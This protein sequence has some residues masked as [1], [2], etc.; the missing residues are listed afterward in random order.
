MATNIL[1]FRR[2]D[3]NTVPPKR[4][5]K[6]RVEALPEWLQDLDIEWIFEEAEDRQNG[7][8]KPFKR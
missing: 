4:S 2:P 6:A 1:L 7:F 8:S 5:A 3:Q